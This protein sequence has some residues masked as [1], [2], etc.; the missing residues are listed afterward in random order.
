MKIKHVFFSSAII[1]L[2]VACSA[3]KKSKQT[4]AVTINEPS[5]ILDTIRVIANETPK[6]KCIKP[7]KPN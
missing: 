2:A 3:T 5:I 4:Q 7:L 1:A 6:K